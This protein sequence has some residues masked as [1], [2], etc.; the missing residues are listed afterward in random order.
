MMRGGYFKGCGM[1]RKDG[2]RGQCC[3]HGFAR[4]GAAMRP[5]ADEGQKKGLGGYLLSRIAAVPSA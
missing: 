2:V 3:V 4:T 1:Q 5:Q